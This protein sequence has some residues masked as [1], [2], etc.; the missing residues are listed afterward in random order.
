VAT[1]I[2]AGFKSAEKVSI[3]ASNNSGAVVLLVIDS[4]TPTANL[5]GAF[6]VDVRIP[7]SMTEAGSPFTIR[8]SGDQNSVAIGVVAVVNK[9][10]TD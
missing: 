6:Q 8:A 4:G 10:T 2:G 1:V 5:A 3:I 9:V 7:A